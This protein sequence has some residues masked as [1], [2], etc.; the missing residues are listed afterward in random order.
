ML[1][2][3]IDKALD[4]AGE[5]N[6]SQQEKGKKGKG[7]KGKSRD[8]PMDGLFPPYRRMDG[9]KRKK[10]NFFVAYLWTLPDF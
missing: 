1:S 10:G 8:F 2:L 6:M 5:Y 7:E 4:L 3:S 9:E